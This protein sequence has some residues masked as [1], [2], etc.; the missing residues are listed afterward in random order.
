MNYDHKVVEYEG[1]EDEYIELSQKY[2]ELV[3]GKRQMESDSD[4]SDKDFVPEGL[5]ETE[6]E[7][8]DA[9]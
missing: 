1:L 7:V 6:A 8:S 3:A 9:P 2:D 5:K 4:S